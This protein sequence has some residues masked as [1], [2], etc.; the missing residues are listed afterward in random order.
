MSR[1]ERTSETASTAY[2]L[3]NATGIPSRGAAGQPR[4]VSTLRRPKP[5]HQ[6]RYNEKE[7]A[8]TPR[9]TKRGIRSQKATD[10]RREERT[11]KRRVARRQFRAR[12]G[13]AETPRPVG[14]QEPRGRQAKWIQ[15]V[16]K[17]MALRVAT[18]NAKGLGVMGKREDVCACVCARACAYVRARVLCVC[19]RALVA[20]ACVC[21]CVFVFV[22]LC[23]R[24][25]ARVCVCVRACA[26][27]CGCLCSCVGA[28]RACLLCVV[29]CVPK[30][31]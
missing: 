17:K 16:K 4:G 2:L 14:A 25:R 12:G 29:S 26:R 11:R 22:R 18:Y 24:A 7:E 21:V 3:N 5:P 30:C 1:R 13:L 8:P 19:V 6:G 27:A 20:R 31:F 9:N 15:K 23:V 28:V 10:R